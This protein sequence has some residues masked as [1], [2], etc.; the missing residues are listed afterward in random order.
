[1]N[2]RS[3]RVLFLLGWALA[4]TLA[5]C[6]T[7]AGRS[8][9]GVPPAFAGVREK[10]VVCVVERL[11]NY[12]THL[13]AIAGLPWRTPYAD[14]YGHTVDAESHQILLRH[15]PLL[16]WGHGVTG[17]LAP[18]FVLL[19][20]Y[21]PLSDE[22]DLFEYMRAVDGA[23]GSRSYD[24]IGDL[25]PREQARLAWWL[26]DYEGFFYSRAD[27][28]ETYLRAVRQL[29][30]V[31]EYN[32]QAWYEEVWN[33]VEL[34]LDLVA[35]ELNSDLW[36]LELLETWERMTGQRFRGDR[37]EVVLTAAPA[38][39]GITSLGYHRSLLSTD[40]DRERMLGLIVN[41]VGTH[42]L[43]DLFRDLSGRDLVEGEQDWTT[44][45]AFAGLT[46]HYTRQILPE[47][48]TEIENDVEIFVGIYRQ[49]A[50]AEPQAGA[51]RLL[52]RAL[53][54]HRDGRW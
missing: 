13:T 8:P 50:D 15:A 28:Y 39:T 25:Y 37:Y 41:E 51:R 44:Y 48:E 43:V 12:I 34:D 52:Q 10:E 29:V 6:A 16:Q 40:M 21:L 11:P 32:Y 38:G 24:A 54:E 26:F 19:P 7:P 17:D 3:R 27:V 2:H 20:S 4:L 47:F 1:M 46:A 14:A 9:G 23:M 18:F 5:R 35:D 36:S 33:D 49:L 22:F 45:A 30:H 31:Y 42:L 53:T